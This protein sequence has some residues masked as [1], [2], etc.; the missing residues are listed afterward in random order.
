V[1][2]KIAASIGEARVRYTPVVGIDSG[3]RVRDIDGYSII[4]PLPEPYIDPGLGA[5]HGIPSTTHQIEIRSKAAR[6]ATSN[7]ATDIGVVCRRAVSRKDRSGV[8][9]SSR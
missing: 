5:L 1:S 9:T 3:T 4:I 8:I 6:V 2:A 7:T